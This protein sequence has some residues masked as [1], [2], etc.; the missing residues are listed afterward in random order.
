M[1][2]IILLAFPKNLLFIVEEYGYSSWVIIL[3]ETTT[4]DEI[5][6]WWSV[7]KGGY[8][9]P[10]PG[11]ESRSQIVWRSE[12]ERTPGW[13]PVSWSKAG[14]IFYMAKR[15][16]DAERR[17]LQYYPEE[18]ALPEGA[19]FAHVHGHDDSFLRLPD[20]EE[21]RHPDYFEGEE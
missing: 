1:S 11:E 10:L 3:D 6:E 18:F 14:D 20:G 8:Y 7:E 12:L 16:E 13:H 9:N 15:V 5:R 21:L 4:V 17:T 2:D 19:I